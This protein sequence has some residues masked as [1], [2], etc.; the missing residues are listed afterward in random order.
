[1]SLLTWLIMLVLVLF[2][3][4]TPSGPSPAPPT[5]PMKFVPRAITVGDLHLEVPYPL[6]GAEPVYT[7]AELDGCSVPEVDVDIFDGPGLRFV[8]VPSGCAIESRA[9]GNGF[10]G[11]FRTVADIPDAGK[12]QS[13]DT[14]VGDATIVSYPYYECTNS[15]T[16]GS[17]TVAIITLDSPTDP[18]LPTL[19]IYQPLLISNGDQAQIDLPGYVAD[20]KPG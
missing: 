18:D 13:V 7:T 17:I 1:V 5:Y 9:P 6:D 10:Y 15:C 2:G 3:V 19:Q 11:Y 16:N 12:A 14:P 8:Q 20:I 4:G